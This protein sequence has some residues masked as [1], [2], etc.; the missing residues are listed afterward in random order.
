MWPKKFFG[1]FSA[2]GPLLL[3]TLGPGPALDGPGYNQDLNELEEKD[4]HI[5]NTDDQAREK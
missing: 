4:V 5:N 1:A 2:G 3:Q